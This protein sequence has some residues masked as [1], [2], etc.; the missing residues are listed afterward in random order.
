MTWGYKETQQL[1]DKLKRT[2]CVHGAFVVIGRIVEDRELLRTIVIY[3]FE[4]LTQNCDRRDNKRILA[5]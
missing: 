4:F 1:L 5:A 2:P 3:G